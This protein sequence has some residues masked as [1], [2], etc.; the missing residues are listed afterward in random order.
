MTPECHGPLAFGSQ[1]P[2]L[3]N[4]EI[5]QDFVCLLSPAQ[6]GLHWP[7]HV[8]DPGNEM[9]A[10]MTGAT[11]KPKC[12]I[13]DAQLTG[14]FFPRDAESGNGCSC[15]GATE[16]FILECWA[17]LCK[18]ASLEQEW[19]LQVWEINF[20]FCWASETIETAWYYSIPWP[21]LTN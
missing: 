5:Y 14:P 17:T 6:G 1:A 11:S 15:R 13:P 4:T 16:E 20:F 2:I 21:K 12:L 8:T 19:P 9:W 7:S 18:T 10:E 3:D